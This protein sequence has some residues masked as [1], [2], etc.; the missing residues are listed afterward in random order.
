MTEQNMYIQQLYKKKKNS[1]A[2][3]TFWGEVFS[4]NSSL[5]QSQFC[6]DISLLYKVYLQP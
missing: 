3:I 6:V 2:I 4:L 5:V 1:L